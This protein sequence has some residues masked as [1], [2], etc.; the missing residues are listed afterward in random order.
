MGIS[1]RNFAILNDDEIVKLPTAKLERLHRFSN[2]ESFPDFKNQKI[3]IALFIVELQNRKP[4]N[5]IKEFYS[6]YEFDSFGRLDREKELEEMNIRMSTGD[7]LSEKERT[8]PN[9]IDGTKKFYKKRVEDQYEWYPSEI[10]K[11][12]L[13]TKI[14]R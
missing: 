2:D 7:F 12:K 14:F 8:A 1:I 10:L 11:N 3:R 5:I 6:Y 9:I 13:H 4:S